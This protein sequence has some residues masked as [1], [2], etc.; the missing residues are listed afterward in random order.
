MQV[1]KRSIILSALLISLM[2]LAQPGAAA[3]K[4]ATAKIPPYTHYW[5]DVATQNMTM[6]GMSEGMGGFMGK[7]MG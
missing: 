1:R 4:G 2:L 7:M 5:V 3:E 6:P